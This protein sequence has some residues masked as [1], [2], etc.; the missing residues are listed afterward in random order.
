MLCV[1]LSLSLTDAVSCLY[2][3]CYVSLQSLS[4]PGFY[5]CIFRDYGFFEVNVL[6]SLIFISLFLLLFLHL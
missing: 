4:F 3:V 2:D 1:S 6:V 5:F